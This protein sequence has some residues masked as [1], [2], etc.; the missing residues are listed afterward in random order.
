MAS[1]VSGRLI[2]NAPGGEFT[3]RAKADRID[4]L[5]DGG[6]AI[7]DYKTGNIPS[8]KQVAAG[9]RPQLSLEAL[10]AEA[11][12]FEDVAPSAV[13]QLAYWKLDGGEPAGV[14]K[15]LKKDAAMLAADAKIGLLR[16]IA[17]FDDPKTPYHALPRPEAKPS[18]NDYAHLE[19]VQEWSSGGTEEEA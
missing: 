15:P 14:M 7:I 19:R 6:L 17:E 5:K 3:L 2:L 9:R 10:I 11:G 8:E 12:G 16:L 18:W 1:E 13:G 4:R